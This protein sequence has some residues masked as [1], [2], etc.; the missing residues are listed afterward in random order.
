MVFF[1]VGGKEFIWLFKYD[2]Y[3]V[4]DSKVYV[5]VIYILFVIVKIMYDWNF[6]KKVVLV[7]YK[8]N[9]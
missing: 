9:Y 7:C 2:F 3:M 4:E 6:N 8:L 5:F 1:F